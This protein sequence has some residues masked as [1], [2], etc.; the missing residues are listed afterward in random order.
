MKSASSICQQLHFALV[1]INGCTF[2]AMEVDRQQIKVD[3]CTLQSAILM[4]ENIEN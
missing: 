4:V 2:P 3:E 1:D